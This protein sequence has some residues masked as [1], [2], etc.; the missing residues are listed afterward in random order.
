MQIRMQNAEALTGQQIDEFLTGSE[1]IG[2][3]G[4]SRAGIYAGT[5]RLLVA[6]EFMR[7]SKK[8]RGAIRR[9][10]S[11]VTG[12]SLPQITRLIRSYAQT[13][14]VELRAS[15]RCRFAGKYTERD[16]TLLAEVD[17]AHER[18]SGSDIGPAADGCETRRKFHPGVC[19]DPFVPNCV[20]AVRC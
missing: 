11:R 3:K 5:E 18:L 4:E 2:F 19:C 14:T 8:R 7:Q 15:L 9:Y 16:V 6:Q 12:L 1:G 17:R 20:R 13:G 10:A